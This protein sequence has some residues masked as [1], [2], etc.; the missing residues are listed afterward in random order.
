MNPRRLT[1]RLWTPPS[2]I[3]FY[4]ASSSSMFSDVSRVHAPQE[5][6]LQSSIRRLKWSDMTPRHHEIRTRQAYRWI[7]Q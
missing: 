2:T 1:N 7:E 4:E 6:R 3:L 5:I